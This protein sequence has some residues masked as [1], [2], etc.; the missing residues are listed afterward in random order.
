MVLISHCRGIIKSC[1]DYGILIHFLDFIGD[2]VYVE[3]WRDDRHT[4]VLKR[5]LTVGNLTE[6]PPNYYEPTCT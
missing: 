2:P 4:I 3:D 5:C 1:H 6:T